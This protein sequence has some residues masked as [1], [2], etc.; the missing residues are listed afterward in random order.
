MVGQCLD[1]RIPIE[2]LSSQKSSNGSDDETPLV[3]S[4]TGCSTFTVPGTSS[5]EAT[6]YRPAVDA[7]GDRP[8]EPI[9]TTV[10][11]Y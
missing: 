3:P 10:V 11:G 1:R 7:I 9:K 2:P 4:S 6:R 5:D 8:P